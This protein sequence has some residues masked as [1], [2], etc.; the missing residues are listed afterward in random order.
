VTPLVV[1]AALALFAGG[2]LTGRSL[3][4]DDDAP[5]PVDTTGTATDGAAAPAP[6][7][8][9]SS[10]DVEPAAAV[11]AAVAP[12]VVQLETTV[13]LGSGVIYDADGHILT[14]AHVLEGVEEL[15]VRLADGTRLAGRVVGADPATDV[16]VVAIDAPPG[17][18]PAVLAIGVP[19]EVGQLAVAVGS[20]FGLEQTVTAGS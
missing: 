8:P 17:L 10:D 18:R 14:A 1:L 5:A 3:A 7:G 6:A 13:G 11:A 19:L 16:G 12:S 2:V 15:T 9:V 4:T 20:P